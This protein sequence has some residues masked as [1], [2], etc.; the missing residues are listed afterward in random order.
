M[1]VGVA[2]GVTGVT[3]VHESPIDAD[4]PSAASLS[5]AAALS[6][7]VHDDVGGGVFVGACA[8]TACVA[9]GVT[10]VP[11]IKESLVNTSVPSAAV[12]SLAAA[13][14]SVFGDDIACDVV[15]GAHVS[16]VASNTPSAAS[17]S[18]SAAVWSFVDN[19]VAIATT[20]AC[21]A[22]SASFV[23]VLQVTHAIA[24]VSDLV[25]RHATTVQ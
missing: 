23:V 6:S 15:V 7:V 4:M 19:N 11:S 9:T 13:M 20:I 24:T 3:W 2:T 12:A 10:A 14:T 21:A 25:L 18:L 1:I 5:S 22:V 16:P 8:V 17:P